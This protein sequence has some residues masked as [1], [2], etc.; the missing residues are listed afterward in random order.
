[1]LRLF[2]EFSRALEGGMVFGDVLSLKLQRL[3]RVQDRLSDIISK[4]HKERDT[5]AAW[6]GGPAPVSVLHAQMK[7]QETRTGVDQLHQI[8]D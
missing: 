2:R 3:T 5:S 8:L 6:D 1:M 7:I 4:K